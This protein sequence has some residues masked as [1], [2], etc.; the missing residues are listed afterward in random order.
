MHC[1]SNMTDTQTLVL[2]SGHPLGLFP[3]HR[4]APRAVITNGMVCL[5]VCLSACLSV[6]IQGRIIHSAGC[7]MGGGPRRQGPRST[8]I[9]LPRCV[10][11]LLTTKKVINFLGEENPGYAHDKTAPPCVGMGSPEWL[12]RPCLYISVCLSRVKVKVGERVSMFCV[13]VVAE[14]GKCLR[15]TSGG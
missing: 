5:S 7:T 4:D 2:Y 10:D 13:Q 12:I 15:E 6:S 3:S 1:L 8:A 11:V 9:F 14:T